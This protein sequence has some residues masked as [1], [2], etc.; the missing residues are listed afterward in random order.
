MVSKEILQTPTP[1]PHNCGTTLGLRRWVKYLPT[2]V[3]VS[4]CLSALKISKVEEE[5]GSRLAFNK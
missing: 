3:R 5:E 1:S 2:Y 4:E